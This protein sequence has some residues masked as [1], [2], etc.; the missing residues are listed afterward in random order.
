MIELSLA[1]QE[2]DMSWMTA[3]P[4]TISNRA[5]WKLPLMLHIRLSERIVPEYAVIQA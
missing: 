4:Y 1:D 3:H 2:V 5:P